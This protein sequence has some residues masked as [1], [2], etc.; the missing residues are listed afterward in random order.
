MLN[1]QGH[2][3]RIMTAPAGLPSP[4]AAP[5]GLAVAGT[6]LAAFLGV[7]RSSAMPVSGGGF[8]VSMAMLVPVV[9]YPSLVFSGPLQEYSGIGVGIGLISGLIL[10]LAL[11]IGGSIP[12]TVG[13][14][15]SEPAVVLGVVATA[16][17]AELEVAGAPER[18]LPTVVMTVAVSAL[19]VGAIFFLLGRLRMG[20]LIR[21]VP[22]P[23][24]VGFIGGMGW[25]LI[26]GAA[27]VV[28]GLSLLPTNLPA[29][30]EPAMLLRWVPALT[31]GAGLWALQRSRPRA[32][33]VPLTAV[34]IVVC[35]WAVVLATGTSPQD[36]AAEGWMLAPVPPLGLW[37]STHWMAMAREVDWNV[38]LN[39]WPEILTLITVSLM[40]VLMQASVIEIAARS[41]GDL[42]RELRA[43][44]VGNAVGSLAGG[45]PGY[46]SLSA[47]LLSIRI[48]R[49]TRATGL[50]VAVITLLI[51]CFGGGA[52]A[53][54]PKLLIGGLLFYVGLDVLIAALLNVHLRRS[55]PE[56][57]VAMLVFVTVA[58]VGLLEGLGVGVAAGVVL[59]VVN[60]SQIDVVRHESSAAEHHSNVVRS[61]RARLLLDELGD[62][63]MIL[64][65]QG[66]IF[67]GTS[68]LLLNRI[69]ARLTG[70]QRPRPRFILLDFR[71]VTGIDSS[72]SLS[73]DKLAQYGQTYAMRLIVSGLSSHLRP[74][75]ERLAQGHPAA[76]RIRIFPDIDHALEYAENQLLATAAAE[77]VEGETLER[78]LAEAGGEEQ[79][80]A[81]L[82]RWVDRRSYGEGEPLISQGEASDDI[83]YVER[84]AV[85]VQLVLPGGRTVRIRTMGAGAVI[86]EIAFYMRLPRSA[87]VVAA[88]ETLAARISAEA[89]ARMRAEAPGA[90][91]LL[92]SF[93]ARQLAEKLVAAT[94]QLASTQR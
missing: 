35:F 67:F 17:A 78:Q 77:S 9:S 54:L 79:E 36:L 41:D 55:W 58:F 83:F 25:L 91:A 38:L 43:L 16:M 37:L 2:S 33:N 40:G 69:R 86:G 6:R 27:R 14:G 94:Q 59:F 74:A 7:D 62:R 18:L 72:V 10:T 84:G 76:S 3:G 50:I 66:Y 23:L 75:F 15:Q 61:A 71:R 52:I 44:G 87:T 81:L 82:M 47:S 8:V 22:Y 70:C 20:N 53:W 28:T 29:L 21:F 85:T 92:H 65:L 63:V 49:P 24:I 88:E 12:G 1:H 68:N 4:P 11:A 42:N 57:A 32:L 51:L 39:H 80:I 45:M 93:L 5:S 56:Y 60:Y 73:L 30:A 89:L 19:A 90:A 26:G 34:G 13:V 48:G 64:E 31:A 46:H